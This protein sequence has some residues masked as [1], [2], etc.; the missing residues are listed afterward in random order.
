M[1]I[2]VQLFFLNTVLAQHNHPAQTKKMEKE[3]LSFAPVISQILSDSLSKYKMESVV[4]T[5]SPSAT[6]TVS[7]FHDCDLFGYVIEGEI[8]IGLENKPPL[9]FKQGQMFYEKKMTLHTLA[10]NVM[11][12]KETRVLLIFIIKEG[13][14]GYIKAY[15]ETSTQ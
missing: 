10:R 12:N 7:H 5:M 9:T 2:A 8:Q 3:A 6:D 1:L 13:A 14:Q 11:R 4:M 15:P